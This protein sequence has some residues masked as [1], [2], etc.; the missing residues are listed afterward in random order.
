MTG[1]A[2]TGAGR[3]AGSTTRPGEASSGMVLIPGGEFWQGAPPWV[4]DW[5]DAEGQAFPNAW[6][7]DETPQRR[8]TTA[9]FW[10]DRYPV[11]VREF[12]GFVRET[13]YRTDAE[14]AGYSMVYGADYWEEREGA[15]WHR[16][17]GTSGDRGAAARATRPGAG[18]G[19][20]GDHPVVHISWNDA[21]AYAAWAGKRLPTETEWELAARGHEFR[22]WPW[23]DV[24]DG[25]NA[26][27]AE[28]SAGGL[29]SLASWREWWQAIYRQHGPVPQT[30]PVGHFRGR[31]DSVFGCA[32]MAGNVYEWTDTLA[33][34]Y[35][36][37]TRCDPT[38]HMV[39]GHS[40][41]VRGGS[42]M[43]LRYQVRCTERMYG[44]PQ[45]WSNF[46]LGFRCARDP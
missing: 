9:P 34:L 36:E 12:A 6:F 46:A 44:D 31:G 15:C 3:P 21:C 10:I 13:G 2:M 29:S 35:D 40:R 22:L 19:G 38:I 11:T 18:A 25:R 30:T 32:D 26:N 16:P 5:L 20:Y 24:W 4:L 41:V 28:F 43:N 42:W 7:A 1:S 17:A 14:R 33:H 45:G 8:A 23:G 39:L 27:T 37:T